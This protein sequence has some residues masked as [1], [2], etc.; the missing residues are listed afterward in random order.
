MLKPNILFLAPRIYGSIGGI[1]KFN[2][3]VVIAAGELAELSLLALRDRTSDIPPI[4]RRAHGCNNNRFVFLMQAA[5]LVRKKNVLLLG[6]INL[7]PVGFLLKLLNP[8]LKLILFVHGIDVWND[9]NFRQKKVFEPLL[10]KYISRVSSV[11]QYTAKQMALHFGVEPKKFFLLPNAIDGPLLPF[12]SSTHKKTLLAVT[13]MSMH[14]RSKNLEAVLFAFAR[15]CPKFPNITLELVGDGELRPILEKLAIQLGIANRVKFLGRLSDV[16]LEACYRRSRCFV[17]PSTKEGFGIVYLE[18]WKHG[19]PVIS[20][21]GGAAPEVVTDG[22]DGFVVDPHDIVGMSA[23]LERFIIDDKMVQR[24]GA[25]GQSKVAERYL[26]HHFK[27][28]I[29]R[30]FEEV[31]NSK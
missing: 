7:L 20:G 11:S 15:I 18:A 8:R 14:D 1:E 4:L 17:L 27:N 30:L 19:L 26:H 22:V 9:P 3:R 2:Q 10:L 28:A 16:E 23:T 12:E 25:A 31:L 13:R 21:N 24:F 29:N 5:K 6:H